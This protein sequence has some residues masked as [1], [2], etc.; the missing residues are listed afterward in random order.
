MARS[1]AELHCL[2]VDAGFAGREPLERWR[3]RPRAD[4]PCCESGGIIGICDKFG[5]L[6][7]G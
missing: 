1:T 5:P 2:E 3:N 7:D 6:A 4:H